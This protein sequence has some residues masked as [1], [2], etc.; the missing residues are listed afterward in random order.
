MF[1]KPVLLAAFG[2]VVISLTFVGLVQVQERINSNNKNNRAKAA[3]NNN[4]DSSSPNN[5]DDPSSGGTD[6]NSG[7]GNSASFVY[8]GTFFIVALLVE[9]VFIYFKICAIQFTETFLLLELGFG[10]LLVL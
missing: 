5:R 9:S 6:G 7:G 2:V 4:D 8:M 3:S 10:F 1:L